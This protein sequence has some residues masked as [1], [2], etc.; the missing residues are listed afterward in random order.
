[1][2]ILVKSTAL[3]LSFWMMSLIFATAVEAGA[4]EKTTSYTSLFSEDKASL[5][6]DFTNLI[7]LENSIKEH[8][9]TDLNALNAAEPNLLASLGLENIKSINSIEAT[10]DFTLD[11]MDW[12][13]FAWGFCCCYIGFFVV[14]VNKNKSQDQKTS[15]WIGTGI[16][17]VLGLINYAINPQAYSANSSTT[18]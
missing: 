10:Q 6:T 9:L 16:S 5:D 12:G 17:L 4:I 13:S 15:F 18:P 1:M 3:F 14:G 8:N 2:N 11:D 7:A